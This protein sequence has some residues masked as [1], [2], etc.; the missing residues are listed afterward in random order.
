MLTIQK[1]TAVCIH[2]RFCLQGVDSWLGY[3]SR[4]GG[5]VL[6]WG[7][8][9]VSLWWRRSRC[10]LL[11]F[12]I[13]LTVFLF[14]FS[15]R[16]LLLLAPLWAS[17]ILAS[18]ERFWLRRCWQRERGRIQ[19]KCTMEQGQKYC[20][21]MVSLWVFFPICF[22]LYLKPSLNLS[23]VSHN[24]FTSTSEVMFVVVCTYMLFA[25][26]IV[27]VQAVCVFY[28]IY[29]KDLIMIFQVGME[30]GDYL[31]VFCHVLLPVAYEVSH[32]EN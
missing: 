26:L 15:Q 22:L 20:T 32:S 1:S 2:L 30:N 14:S 24:V 13:L 23:T 27:C 12:Q 4:S 19:Y 7:W 25:F 10:C 31:S 9:Q 11:A 16:A 28:S 29:W 18:S 6:L 8:S 17:E 3:T 21:L 5:A